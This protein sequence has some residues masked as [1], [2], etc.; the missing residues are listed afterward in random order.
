MALDVPDSR[1][2]RPEDIPD[3][4]PSA[5]EHVG[6]PDSLA[7]V[8]YTS[9]STGRPKG[10]RVPHRQL[11]NWLSALEARVPF[12]AGEVVGQKTTAVFAVGVK[13]LFAGLLN[14]CPQVVLADPVVRDTPAFADALAEHRV[15]RLNLVPSHLAGLLEHL[16]AS[17]KRLPALRICVTAGEPLPGSLVVAFREL[18]PGARLLN[19]YGCTELND[20]SYYDTAGF[21]GDDGFVPIGTPIAN[22]R[23][24]VLDRHGRLVPDGVPGELHV[25]SAGIPDGYHGRDDLTAERFVPNPFGD[26]PSD[27]LY[28]TGDVVRHLPDGTLDFIGRWDFQVKVRGFR[29]EVRQVEKVMGDFDGIGARAVVG[30]GDRLVA[31]YTSRPGRTV[32]GARLRAFLHDRLPAYLVADVLVP[33]DAMPAL[34]NGKL[35][36][37]ALLGLHAR[38][39]PGDDHEP[40]AGATERALADIWALIVNVPVAHLGRRTHFFDIGGHSLSAMR[41]LARIKEEFGVEVGLSELFDAPRLDT[42]AATIDRKIERRRSDGPT[43]ARTPAPQPR[44]TGSGLL[45]DKVVLVTG[46]SRGI[47][48]A[49]ALLVASHGAKVAVNYRTGEADARRAKDLIEAQGGVAEVFRAD[50]TCPDEVG[51]MVAAVTDRFGRIDVLV[52]NAHMPYRQGPVLDL[53]WADLERKVNDELKAVFHP[54][55]AVAPGMLERRSGSIIALSGTVSKQSDNGSVAQSTAKAAVDALVRSLAAEFGP[56]GVRVNTVAPGVTLTDAALG[57]TATAREDAAARSP[58]R[59]N[60]LPEDVAGAVLFLASDLARFMTGAY[61]PVDGG[62]TTV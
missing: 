5:P 24:Y 12:E 15:T 36:R 59:R 13:E 32:D 39:G 40:P 8:M 23:V 31:F 54:C 51:A 49:T 20:I 19:N 4:A 30:Q 28:N 58:M 62:S 55:R 45:A 44:I 16:R 29:V 3:V 25:A 42:V 2:V 34:P 38:Q 11:T 60:A 57:M 56:R 7:Y 35:D 6:G 10:V 48:L 53:D 26:W 41:V 33:L 37:R 43:P 47:G 46:G 22:T 1:C 9:G 61:L 14:G 17:G 27:H 18:L 52:A 50:V 21:G